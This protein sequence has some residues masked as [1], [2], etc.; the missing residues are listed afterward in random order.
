MNHETTVKACRCLRCG[1]VWVPRGGEPKTCANCRSAYWNEP[2]VRAP[3][4]VLGRV[5]DGETVQ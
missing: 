2:R 5:P 1:Y 3:R 4:K